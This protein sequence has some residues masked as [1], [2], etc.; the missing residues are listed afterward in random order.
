MTGA[1]KTELAHFLDLSSYTLK[2]RYRGREPN[3]QF[4][5]DIDTDNSRQNQDTG[6]TDTIKAIAEE[7][8]KCTDC[9]LCKNRKKAV[10]GKGVSM[11][12]LLIIGKGPGLN[13]DAEGLP[14]AGVSG[15]RLDKMLAPIGLSFNTNCFLTGIVKCITPNE[16]EPL[17]EE[18]ISCAKYLY[19]EI[20]ALDP[21]IILCTGRIAAQS[22]LRT[23]EEINVIRN[24][25]SKLRIGDKIY[26]V[27]VT[28]HPDEIWENTE[29]KRPAWEDLK[30]L[31]ALLDSP[32]TGAL[33]NN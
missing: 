23:N 32:K 3:Y 5:D 30:N 8:L 16:R 4:T 9:R 10:P 24:C 6:K 2:S 18:T 15:E 19:R 1:E 17:P 25:G 27:I 14:F 29:L 20:S 7:I 22:L 28:Y 11:P 21:E 31:K 12:L 13:E 33:E 26:P